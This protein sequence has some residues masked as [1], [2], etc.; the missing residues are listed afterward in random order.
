MDL[1][2]LDDSGAYVDPFWQLLHEDVQVL[3]E[4]DTFVGAPRLQD[5]CTRERTEFGYG[6]RQPD[7]LLCPLWLHKP[8][9]HPP[10]E[11]LGPLEGAVYLLGQ[12]GQRPARGGRQGARAAAVCGNGSGIDEK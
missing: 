3:G 2:R 12:P 7:Q 11:R 5:A 9:G 6:V 8:R 10:P 4:C 1:F